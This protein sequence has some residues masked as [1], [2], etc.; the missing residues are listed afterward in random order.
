MATVRHNYCTPEEY[1]EKDSAADYKS[2]Y[3]AGEMFAMS[4]GSLEHNTIIS[5]IVVRLD[6]QLELR[7]CRQ[8]MTDVRVNVGAAFFYPDILVVCGDINLL[9][10]RR[11]VILNPTVIMEVLSKS[12]EA[13]DRGEKFARY[14][15][16]LTLT[17]FI[18]IS[19]DQIRVE[20]YTRQADKKWLLSIYTTLDDIITIDSIGCSLNV[21]SIYRNIDFQPFLM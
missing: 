19:Q 7:P 10:N 8:F 6:S 15:E 11:D 18:L 21:S 13:Y 4:G 9:D 17:D 12:T 2:E 20:H 3:L 14:S 16:L 5:N 1:L